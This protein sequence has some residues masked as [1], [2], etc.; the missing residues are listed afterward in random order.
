MRNFKLIIPIFLFL[1]LSVFWAVPSMAASYTGGPGAGWGYAVKS[2]SAATEFVSSIRSD[3]GGA[4][5]YSSL[6]AWN[7]AVACDLTAGGTKVFAGALT[8]ALTDGAGVTLYRG[9][10]SQGITATV[11]HYNGSMVLVTG[12]SSTAFSFA[13][14]DQWR[15]DSTDYVMISSTGASAIATAQINGTWASAEIAPLSISSPWNT[16]PTNYIKIY[17]GTG[18]VNTG[19]WS[20]SAYRLVVSVTTSNTYALNIAENYV[21]VTGLQIGLT[22][23]SGTNV[24][25]CSAVNISSL[26]GVSLIT[27]QKNIINGTLSG[28][29]NTGT[30]ITSADNDSL[31]VINL[32]N[33][34]VPVLVNIP[35][36]DRFVS[37]LK[38]TVIFSLSIKVAQKVLIEGCSKISSGFHFFRF[39]IRHFHEQEAI[40]FIAS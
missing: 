20:T 15:A 4:S 38:R 11:V 19:I 32:Y 16:S 29:G 2:S 9:G 28:T 27:L 33:N 22:N 37:Q 39:R 7:A 23:N 21:Q 34:I 25:G 17:T 26:T 24:T 5:D 31:A 6:S 40:L 12:I 3:G 8:G 30:G 35:S 10:A 14:G 13:V 18:A 36:K 1:A